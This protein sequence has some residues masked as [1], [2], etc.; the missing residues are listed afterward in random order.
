[1]YMHPIPSPSRL[2]PL[3]FL[4]LFHMLDLF[5]TDETFDTGNAQS[6]MCIRESL[7]YLHDSMT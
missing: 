1:M 3:M 6:I 4:P 2:S 7:G 5:D